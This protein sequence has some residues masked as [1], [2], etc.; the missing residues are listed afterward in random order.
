[1]AAS[2]EEKWSIDKLDAS[3]WMTWKFQMRHLLLAKGL[4]G[5]VDGSEVLAPGANEQARDT[6]RLKEQKAFSSI[7]MAISTSQLYLVTS[8]EGPKEAWDTL[9]NHNERGTLANKLFL[10][11]QYFRSEMK[12]GSPM[13][14]HL[15]NMKEI[16][17]KLA[18]I[19]SP[20]SEEDQVVTLLGSLPSKYS[21]LVTALEARVD[22]VSLKFVQQALIHEEQKQSGQ[23][24]S[25]RVGVSGGEMDSVLMGAHKRSKQ[26]NQV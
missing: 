7:V 25:A 1:M 17:D 12:E 6:F 10:K 26:Q 2:M 19:G 13:E 18:A 15:K 22:L 16:T 9:R 24:G 23:F 5:Q 3:N 20:I 11:K 4:W 8:C 21:T 14:T